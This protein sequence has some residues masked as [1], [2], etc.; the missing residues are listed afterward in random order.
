MHA[1]LLGV[2][3]ALE[4]LLTHFE[5]LPTEQIPLSKALSRVLAED[6]F[7]GHPL[8]PFNNSSMDG[9][10]VRSQD[11]IGASKISPVALDVIG[12]ISSGVIELMPLT[13]KTAMRIMTGAPLPP[14]ADSVVPVEETSR[15]NAMAHQDLPENVLILTPVQKG[16]YI[17]DT[18]QDVSQGQKVLER[19]HRLRPQDIGMLAA[20]G[21]A[22]PLVHSIPKVAL[23][24]S[25]DELVDVADDLL[26]GF[27]RDSNGYSLSAAV[28]AVNATPLRMGI[29]PDD[30]ERVEE[31]LQDAVETGVNLIVS[32]AGVSM[33]AFDFVR[34]VIEKRGRLEFWRINLRPGKPLIF[35]FFDEVPV[36]GL[37]G[38][39]VSAL[40][41]FEIFVRPAVDKLSGVL[42]TKRKKFHAILDHDIE[43]DGRESYLRASVKWNGDTY[44]AK[45]VGSQDSGVLS[46]LVEA[47]ALIIIPA[48]V[49]SVE[50]GSIVEAWHLS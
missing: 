16:D 1:E 8:P 10:A 43:S 20:V 47:N 50:Q 15:P 18:G 27:I 35:G 49:Q 48:G 9:Y 40:V 46:S 36:L 37:P 29:A 7:A 25:G 17:R 32:S 39:P 4:K 34:S 22:E 31:M 13:E 44:K 6:I 26:P 42:T 30:P 23:L 19:G 11:L 28:H 2:S 38:N 33:G 24:S 3:E 12:D 14:G 5:P 45:L 41:T 21:I